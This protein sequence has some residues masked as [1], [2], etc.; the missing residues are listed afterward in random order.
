GAPGRR[1]APLGLP[2]GAAEDDRSLRPE[3]PV[4]LARTARRRR[5][6]LGIVRA[7]DQAR[8][9]GSPRVDDRAAD[10][11]GG[12]ED[13]GPESALADEAQFELLAADLDHRAVP[14]PLPVVGDVLAVDF[15]RSAADAREREPLGT[16]EDRGVVPAL[17]ADAGQR[18]LE[19]DRRTGV[20]AGDPAQRGDGQRE[21]QRARLG[22]WRAR[23]DR[24]KPGVG[25][26]EDHRAVPLARYHALVVDVAD[27]EVEDL[28]RVP[29][30][31]EMARDA[32]AVHERAIRALEIEQ[33]VI[34][35]ADLDRRVLLAHR[36][37]VK[38]DV[39]AI[40]AADGE[41]SI[42]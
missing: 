35:A 31:Q 9:A 29:V 22:R 37:I 24:D 12:A 20:L 26:A 33:H 17:L 38:L 7:G 1:G 8:R 41:P 5:V 30:V 34:G 3:E 36:G 25:G 21:L 23:G 6:W 40:G 13:L 39:D 19:A 32:R 11:R 2:A 16:A 18:P 15:R 28:D 42:L 10:S 27:L 4:R 14:Q